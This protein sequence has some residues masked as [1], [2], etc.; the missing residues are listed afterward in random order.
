MMAGHAV[1]TVTLFAEADV[2]ALMEVRERLKPKSEA[3]GVKLTPLAFITKAVCS[4]LKTYP[5]FNSTLSADTINLIPNENIGIAVDTPKGLVVPVVKNAESLS[6]LDIARQIQVLADAARKDA[7]TLDQMRGSTFTISSIGAGRVEGFTQ[8]LNTPEEGILGVGGIL[9]KPHVHGGAI[10]IRKTV[11]LAL[12]FDHRVA[13][14]AAGAKFL[15]TLVEMLED[16][17]LML[18]EGV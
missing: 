8:I 17:E 5:I 13:D 4:V 10:A 1:P 14:G 11:T 7:L 2:T 15:T 6:I 9:E 18:L 3:A 12:T 16:P